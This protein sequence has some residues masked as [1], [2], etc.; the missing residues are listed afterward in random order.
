VYDFKGDGTIDAFYLI[1][2]V[3]ATNMNPTLRYL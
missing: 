3:R 2:L 1:D